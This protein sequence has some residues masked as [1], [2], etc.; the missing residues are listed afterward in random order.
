M[1]DQEQL[2]VAVKTRCGDI[3][4]DI[5]GPVSWAQRRLARDHNDIHP[6]PNINAFTDVNYRPDL[7]HLSDAGIERVSDIW[8]KMLVGNDAIQSNPAS[9]R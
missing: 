3:G 1:A 4:P 8:A 9:Q 2:Y 7:C 6:G 5:E